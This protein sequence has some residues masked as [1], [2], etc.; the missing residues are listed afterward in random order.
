M[1]K[2]DLRVVKTLEAI[3]QEFV[4]LI[5]KKPLNKISVSELARN[6]RINPGTFYLHY[7]DIYD[8][9]DQLLKK[10][11]MA[12]FKDGKLADLLFEDIDLFIETFH[13]AIQN[14]LDDLIDISN[15]I[16]ATSHT[17]STIEAFKDTV[18]GKGLLKRNELN[19]MKLEAI[20]STMLST[21]PSHFTQNKKETKKILSSVISS[22]LSL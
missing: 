8:L 13:M 20:I 14:T 5:K 16:P 15:G 1:N 11:L 7:Q 22:V 17:T 18:F 19:E 10:R 12:P 21:M 6:A 2:N 9:Y 4:K 3:E